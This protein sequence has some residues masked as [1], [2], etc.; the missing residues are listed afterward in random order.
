MAWISNSDIGNAMDEWDDPE[1][2][3]NREVLHM[4][5]EMRRR[6]ASLEN[7][8]KSLENEITNMKCEK[9]QASTENNEENTKKE[10]N[11]DDC[12]AEKKK[13]DDDD[14]ITTLLDILTNKRHFVECVVKVILMY[15]AAQIFILTGFFFF[16]RTE[17]DDYIMKIQQILHYVL[18]FV[19][20][21]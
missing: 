14:D 6:M 1:T 4:F 20:N 13:Q 15:G 7:Q 21:C 3:M 2:S 17:F 12:Q 9:N 5:D 11:I 10:N 8:V 18:S 19:K 16:D